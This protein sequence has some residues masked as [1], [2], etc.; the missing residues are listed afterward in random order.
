MKN[1]RYI[2]ILILMLMIPFAVSA[3]ITD[4]LVGDA[5]VAP[6]S[7]VQSLQT[8]QTLQATVPQGNSDSMTGTV[9]VALFFVESNGAIDPDQYGWTPADEQSVIAQA[10]QAFSWW[11]EQ[12]AAYGNSVTFKVIP[13]SSATPAVSD[14]ST[15]PTLSTAFTNPGF[16]ISSEHN[17]FICFIRDDGSAPDCHVAVDGVLFLE[18]VAALEVEPR[19]R[20]GVGVGPGHEIPRFSRSDPLASLGAS[21]PSSVL[22][23][24]CVRDGVSQPRRHGELPAVPMASDPAAACA[25][26]LRQRQPQRSARNQLRHFLLSHAV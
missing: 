7:Y 18:R 5:I 8:S 25:V 14:L 2:A 17:A 16:S 10:E 6:A 21:V 4:L 1:T 24:Q 20:R 23:Q 22:S 12:A 26:H 11:S 15:T 19:S 13:Y 3:E 9:A